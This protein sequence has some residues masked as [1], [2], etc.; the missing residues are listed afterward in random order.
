MAGNAFVYFCGFEFSLNVFKLG[1]ISNIH[2][3]SALPNVVE[4]LKSGCIVLGFGVVVVNV[5]IF[6]A[7]ICNGI[8]G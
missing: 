2:F 8:P 6:C 3:V 4:F 5:I 7:R 1:D